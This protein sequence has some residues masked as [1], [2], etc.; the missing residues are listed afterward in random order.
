MCQVQGSSSG[1]PK[2]LAQSRELEVPRCSGSPSASQFLLVPLLPTGSFCSLQ[3]WLET[4]QKLSSLAN[5]APR[6]AAA[7]SP[8]L[9]PDPEPGSLPVCSHY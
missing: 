2:W 4:G 8:A 1:Q 3:I 6:K 9:K 7:T 5:P